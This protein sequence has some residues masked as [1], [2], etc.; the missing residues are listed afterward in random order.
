MSGAG[1]FRVGGPAGTRKPSWV[2]TPGHV[3]LGVGI[4][5]T[6]QSAREYRWLKEGKYFIKAE[7]PVSN[8]T[9]KKTL[10][11]VQLNRKVVTAVREI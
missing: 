9:E 3:A 7:R 10:N 5:L 11:E 2:P 4:M 1:E 6:K 8:H